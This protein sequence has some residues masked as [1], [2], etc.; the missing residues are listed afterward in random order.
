MGEEEEDRARED[1]EKEDEE[2]GK[3]RDAVFVQEVV[4]SV[5]GNA[6]GVQCVQEVVEGVLGLHVELA[7]ERD[8][9][10]CSYDGGGI[11]RLVV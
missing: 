9:H 1:Y 4:N 7:E 10:S 5:N 3:G 11:K 6:V 2:D 8:Y